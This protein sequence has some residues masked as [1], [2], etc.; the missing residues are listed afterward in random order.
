MPPWRGRE[1]SAPCLSRL[2]LEEITHPGTAG[3]YPTVVI[4]P[5]VGLLGGGTAVARPV[6][7]T[8][9]LEAS[10]ASVELLAV[11]DVEMRRG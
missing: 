2:R 9:R 4:R 11:Y 10:E 1:P 7:P 5:G 8:R 3:V 6:T